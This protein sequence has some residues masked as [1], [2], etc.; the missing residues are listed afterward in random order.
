MNLIKSI[1]ELPNFFSAFTKQF[2]DSLKT[3]ETFCQQFSPNIAAT[4]LRNIL[5]YALNRTNYCAYK[6]LDH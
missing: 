1:P 2:Y 4:F 3:G 5:Y 6:K